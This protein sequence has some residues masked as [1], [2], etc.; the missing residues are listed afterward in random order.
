MMFFD[1]G[2]TDVVDSAQPMI[3]VASRIVLKGH[4]AAI[5]VVGHADSVEFKDNPEIAAA[6]AFAVRS[7]LIRAGVP[8]DKIKASAGSQSETMAPESKGQKEPRDRRVVLTFSR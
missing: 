8:A 7:A 5:T 4:A 1:Y 2:L 3:D 6:R